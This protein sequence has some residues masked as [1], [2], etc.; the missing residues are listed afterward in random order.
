MKNVC[1]EYHYREYKKR[2]QVQTQNYYLK[3]NNKKMESMRKNIRCSWTRNEWVKHIEKNSN[4]IK[5][6]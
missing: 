1:N 4:D 5:T 6:F 3:D 2:I